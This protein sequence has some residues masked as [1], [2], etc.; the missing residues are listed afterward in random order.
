M[1]ANQDAAFERF[2]GLF[3]LVA[4]ISGL[5]VLAAQLEFPRGGAN[6]VS[7]FEIATWLAAFAGAVVALRRAHDPAQLIGIRKL[8]TVVGLTLAAAI[9]L[10]L[11][12]ALSGAN[13]SLRAAVDASLTVIIAIGIVSTARLTERGSWLRR[14][15]W[16]IAGVQATAA[17]MDIFAHGRDS[18]P[19]EF[20]ELLSAEVY[21]L[22]L[23]AAPPA[24]PIAFA[25]DGSRV[26]ANARRV[27]HELGLMGTPRYPHLA[28]VKYPV[29][30]EAVLF[31]VMAYLVLTAG[32]AA[33]RASG[34]GLAAQFWDMTVLWFREGI[35]PPTYYSQQF[36]RPG[37]HADFAG[38]LTPFETKNGILTGLNTQRPRPYPRNEMSD[39]AL[40]AEV[41]A[42]HGIKQAATLARGEGGQV[43]VLAGLDID[44]FIKLRKS[45]GAVG[46]Q[47]LRYLGDGVHRHEDGRTFD[48]KSL[49]DFLASESLK[50]PILAQPWLANHKDIAGL[51]KDSL[52]TFR[53]ITCRNENEEP[54]VGVATL[55]LLAKLEPGWKDLVPDEEYACAI[56]LE[57][58]RLGRMWGDHMNTSAIC[59]DRHVVTGAPLAGRTVPMW[60]EIK[61]L[62]IAAHK[63][64]PHR[65]L[66]GWDI[67]LTDS[68]PVVLEGN[69]NCDVMF[70]QR[71]H[72][73]PMSRL[74]LGQL[75]NRQ[76]AKLYA[77]RTA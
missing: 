60:A 72:E 61:G 51:A 48:R 9:A 13:G 33:K 23:V 28:L 70:V 56:D 30:R 4:A 43:N 75:M 6:A 74:K 73:R 34:R 76:L 54:E 22:T 40:F 55:R 69:T 21:L 36:F 1:S 31:A 37:Q 29:G 49:L 8:W 46:T 26:G 7:P 15:L 38:Y 44:L 52:L 2:S 39:K 10:Q 14:A 19:L 67:G 16:V 59:Y 63:A 17:A 64:F 53:V 18:V 68:G 3:P 65:T 27:F 41:C 58:G 47:S 50:A 42:E 57:T 5:C 77:A 35:D 45:M 11:F 62:A 66:V 20:L 71:V 25:N 12:G 32:R 24:A